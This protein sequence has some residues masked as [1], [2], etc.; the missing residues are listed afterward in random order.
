MKFELRQHFRIESAR[1]LTG[2]PE[3]HPCAR[4]HGHSFQIV[5]TLVGEK[6]PKTGWVMDYHEISRVM[7]PLLKDLDHR[8][9][10]EVPGLENPTSENLALWIFERAKRKIESLT[11]VTVMETPQTECSYPA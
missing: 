9:L 10:N 6:D 2:L 3:S 7:E 1:R 4:L 8:V 5:L 11:R